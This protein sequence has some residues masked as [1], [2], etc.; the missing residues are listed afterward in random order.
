MKKRNIIETNVRMRGNLGLKGKVRGSLGKQKIFTE[1][2][3]SMG[4]R[5]I[6]SDSNPRSATYILYD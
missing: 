4:L 6:K 3:R 2:V 1:L 5:I